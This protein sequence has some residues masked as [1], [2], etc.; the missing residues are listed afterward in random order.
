MSM[1]AV[2]PFLLDQNSKLSEA[3]RLARQASLIS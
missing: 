2:L 1:S 3:P